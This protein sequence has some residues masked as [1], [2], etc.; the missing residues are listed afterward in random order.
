MKKELIES[1]A[2]SLA[3]AMGQIPS[4]DYRIYVEPEVA[5][6][7]FQILGNG[8]ES[9]FVNALNHVIPPDWHGNMG[10]KVGVGVENTRVIYVYVIK[11]YLPN[12]YNDSLLVLALDKL[13]LEFKCDEYNPIRN[14]S[15]AL[16]YRFWWD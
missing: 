2:K 13:A 14:D 11:A 8:I 15:A 3:I 9:D 16:I 4:N 6:R 5:A 12:D 10:H 7:V 1:K